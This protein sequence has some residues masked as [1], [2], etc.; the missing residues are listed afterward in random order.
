MRNSRDLVQHV[1]RK[2]VGQEV[3][4][5]I[6]RD[7]KETT[8]PVKTEQMPGEM[9]AEAELP[10]IGKEWF[11]LKVEEITPQLAKRWA[12]TADRGVVVVQVE[13][14]STGHN[15]RVQPGDVILEVNRKKIGDLK[16]YYLAMQGANP[17]EG[18][19]FLINR[20]GGNIFVILQEG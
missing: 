20:R 4:L 11:G 6:R 18:V 14:G 5:T 8:I 2:E 10:E 19:L 16:D 9:R 13:P 12:I 17:R 3:R 7:G 15:A 1:L